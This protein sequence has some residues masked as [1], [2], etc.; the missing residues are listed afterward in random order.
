MITVKP[1]FV[2]IH[3]AWHDQHTW[4]AVLPQLQAHGY[5]AEALDLPGAG[6]HAAR[7]ASFFRRPLDPAAFATEPSPNAGVTQ[8]ER[9]AAVLAKIDEVAGRTRGKVVV[10]AHSLGGVSLTPVAEAHPEKMA[11]AVYLAGSLLATGESVFSFSQTPAMAQT[12]SALL[13]MADPGVVGAVRLDVAST[14]PEYRARL[15]TVFYGDLGDAAFE[16]AKTHLHPDEPVAVFATP[17]VISPGRFGSVPRHYIR[18]TEDLNI[19]LAAQDGMI[20]RVDEE[21][22]SKTQQHTLHTDHSP[23]YSEPQ[24]VAD[25]LMGIAEQHA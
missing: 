1:G 12:Q 25:I 9:N 4:E 7:P 10:V 3:G 6:E 14:D 16:Q 18:T 22:G 5:V 11:A 19:P 13:L 24:A 15:K 21:L 2:L 23:F 17:S 8:E 20:A